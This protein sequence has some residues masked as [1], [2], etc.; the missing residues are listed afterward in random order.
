MTTADED[1]A[2]HAPGVILPPADPIGTL[3]LKKSRDFTAAAAFN[4]LL[5][6][7]EKGDKVANGLAGWGK[8]LHELKDQSAPIV[9][10]L[11]RQ[12]GN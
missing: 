5:E 8:V 3:D 2:A 4:K 12:L 7:A 6:V 10:W 1:R 11:W 9:D